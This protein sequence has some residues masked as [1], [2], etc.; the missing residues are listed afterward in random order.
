MLGSINIFGWFCEILLS[1]WICNRVL[2]WQQSWWAN[3][4]G[5]ADWRKKFCRSHPFP[6]NK[7]KADVSR[8]VIY[9]RC[10]K[11]RYTVCIGPILLKWNL[12]QVSEDKPYRPVLQP[13][14]QGWKFAHSLIGSSLFCSK[15]LI[16]K[17]NHERF[18]QKTDEWIPNP[19]F[20]PSS[21]FKTIPVFTVKSLGRECTSPKREREKKTLFS[22][23]QLVWTWAWWRWW[24]AWTLETSPFCAYRY[25]SLRSLLWLG[26]W[27]KKVLIFLPIQC[28]I[29]TKNVDQLVLQ[30]C[31][32]K[33][34]QRS[35]KAPWQWQTVQS[36]SEFSK[37]F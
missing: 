25:I 17:S 34:C 22:P 12:H 18:T 4:I 7:Y 35:C 8:Y 27:L 32:T 28:L 9:S 20:P 5:M 3:A 37:S 13:I 36:E 15:S 30:N 29:S 24:S 11:V 10:H 33:Q 16:L 2:T 23:E 14:S 21:P 31:L 26:I 19:A 1:L 6:D